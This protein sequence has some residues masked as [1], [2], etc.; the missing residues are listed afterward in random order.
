MC[1]KK[2]EKLWHYCRL[3]IQRILI[4]REHLKYG[5]FILVKANREKDWAA[6]SFLLQKKKLKKMAIEKS[7]FGLLKAIPMH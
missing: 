5:A 7:L 6:N 3:E 1:L 2:K 4:K